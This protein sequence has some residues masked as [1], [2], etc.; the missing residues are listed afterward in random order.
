MK[1]I[2]AQLYGKTDRV[3]G[4]IIIVQMMITYYTCHLKFNTI[5][6][7]YQWQFSLTGTNNSEVCMKIQENMNSQ[8]NLKYGGVRFPDFRRYYTANRNTQ[9]W[10]KKDTQTKGTGQIPESNPCTYDESTK[11]ARIYTGEIQSLQ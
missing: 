2:T 8:N 5:P 6:V 1:S 9:H 4:L 3:L 7:K 11:E 10:P